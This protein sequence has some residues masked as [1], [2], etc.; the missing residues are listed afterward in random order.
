MAND[1]EILSVSP[2]EGSGRPGVNGSQRRATASPTEHARSGAEA[3]P[4]VEVYLQLCRVFDLAVALGILLTAFLVTNIGRMPHGFAEFL[5]IRLT[6]RNLL[7]LLGFAVAWRLVC[8]ASR[9]YEWSRVESVSGESRRVMLTA[10]LGGAAALVFPLISETGAFQ[11]RTV[12]LS[13]LGIGLGMLVLRRALRGLLDVRPRE[14]RTVLIVGSG[15]RAIRLADD[16][17]RSD[18]DARVVGFVDAGAAPHAA[19]VGAR[20]LGDLENLEQILLAHPVS[21]VYVALPVRSR[22]E[23]SQRAI[24]ACE[25]AGVRVNYQADV[26]EDTPGKRSYEDSERGG[27]ISISGAPNDHRIVLKRLADVVGA[28]VSL[29]LALPILAV[30]AAAIKLTSPGPVLY[31]QER[32]GLNR[33]RFRMYKLRTMVAGAESL[34][35]GLESLNEAMGPVFKIK[36]DPRITPVGGVLRRT[37]IDELPQLVN[38]LRGEMSLVGPRPLPLRDVHGFTETTLVRRFS[39]RPGIT[40]LWQVNGR[41]ELS[42]ERW[43]E[44]DLRYVD[45]WSL[46]LDFQILLRTLPAVVK[47]T[48]AA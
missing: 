24:A 20:Y 37:S 19:E 39:V 29:A 21:E 40:G 12:L 5:G 47:G 15:A 33:R 41:S 48:G 30:A 28:A 18:A 43:A 38:V 9:L 31:T 13:V 42:F 3:G 10:V 23:E 44:L 34:Q 1:P 46:A 36:H 11:I 8:R 4:T 27:V 14:I 26:F 16:L 25:A 22:Y 2:R 6:I 7:L 32:Y 17:A 45:E 35:P